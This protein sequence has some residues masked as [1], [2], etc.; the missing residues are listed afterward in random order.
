MVTKF[1]SAKGRYDSLAQSRYK[2]NTYG[3]AGFSVPEEDVPQGEAH[4][5]Y[6]KLLFDKRWIE[7]RKEIIHRDNGKCVNCKSEV[8]LHVH[9]R[10]YHFVKALQKFKAPWEYESYLMITL[11]E[12]CHMKGHR[13]FKVPNVYV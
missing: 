2:A 6:G 7:K 3:K 13:K 5:T 10:Q 11:C 8:A 12:R 9:H 1:N 4:G